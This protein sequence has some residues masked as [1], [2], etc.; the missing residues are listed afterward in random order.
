MWHVLCVPRLPVYVLRWMLN[1][2]LRH[3][4]GG[5]DLDSPRRCRMLRMRRGGC[6]Y[7]FEVLGS[8]SLQRNTLRRDEPNDRAYGALSKGADG[9]EATVVRD[10]P[11]AP[12]VLPKGPLNRRL[13]RGT[14]GKT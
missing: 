6:L 12:P 10:P 5:R 9:R 13:L 7:L 4:K 1:N 2:E 11:R 14:C 3:D 8:M